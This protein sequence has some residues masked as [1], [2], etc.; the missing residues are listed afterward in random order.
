MSTRKFVRA[1]VRVPAPGTRTS[2]PANRHPRRP[3]LAGSRS[4]GRPGNTRRVSTR[5]FARANV[6]V[7]APGTRTSARANGIHVL[8]PRQCAGPGTEHPQFGADD[9]HQ[10]PGPPVARRRLAL[11]VR[12]SERSRRS[13]VEPTPQGPGPAAITL[14]G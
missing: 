8:R 5:K 3:Q 6:R 13:D 4:G 7:A 11:D 10:L 12:T 9:P 14:E 2:A 1:N